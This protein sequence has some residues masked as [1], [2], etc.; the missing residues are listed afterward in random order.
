MYEYKYYT[1]PH[2]LSFRN[3][4]FTLKCLHKKLVGIGDPTT[5][6]NVARALCCVYYTTI[7]NVC[8]EF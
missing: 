4:N 8:F 2:S 7:V 3:T 1:P 5:D 6:G